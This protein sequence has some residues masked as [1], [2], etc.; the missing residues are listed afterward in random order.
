MERA[1]HAALEDRPEAFDGL[2]MDRANDILTSGMVN[3]AVRIFAVKPLVAGPL[4]RAK[5]ADL[6]G[7]GFA[8][9]CGES[10]GTDICDYAR[11]HIALA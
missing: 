4:V 1:D 2:S 7:D 5:Q 3:D 8:N 11:N 10:I 9:E 6:V